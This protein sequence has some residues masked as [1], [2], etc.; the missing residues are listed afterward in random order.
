QILKEG[1]SVRRV[2]ELARQ[3]ATPDPLVAPEPKPTKSSKDYGR[4]DVFAHSLSDFSPTPVK[5]ARTA[6]GKGSITFK[7][8][9]DDELQQLVELFEKM[10]NS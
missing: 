8:T 4:F 5:F 3:L 6:D 10:K 1:L 7:F 9:S 2:E